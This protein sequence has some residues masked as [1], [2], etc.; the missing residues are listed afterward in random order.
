MTEQKAEC[1]ALATYLDPEKEMDEKKEKE[2]DADAQGVHWTINEVV[3]DVH[4][5]YIAR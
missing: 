4:I 5:V 1:A 2:V 3:L